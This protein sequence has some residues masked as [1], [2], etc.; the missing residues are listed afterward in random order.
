MTAFGGTDCGKVLLEREKAN[1]RDRA[2]THTDRP[3]ED[4]EGLDQTAKTDSLLLLVLVADLTR[5]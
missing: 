1:I 3:I 4:R 2:I 5:R